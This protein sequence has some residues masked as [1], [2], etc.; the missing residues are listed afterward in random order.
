MVEVVG[1]GIKKLKRIR[2][3]NIELGTL[4]EGS[5]RSLTSSEK[6]I[7]LDGIIKKELV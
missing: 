1:H 6:Q 2:V 3:E 7:L 4:E 5:Y